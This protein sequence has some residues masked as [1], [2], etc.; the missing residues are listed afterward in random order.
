MAQAATTVFIGCSSTDYA[1]HAA[2]H[3]N[4]IINRRYALV[5][6]NPRLS[7]LSRAEHSAQPHPSVFRTRSPTHRSIS[8]SHRIF[9]ALTTHTRLC[10][11]WTRLRQSGALLG[12]CRRSSS[13]CATITETCTTCHIFR[14]QP[15]CLHSGRCL[16]AASCG[17]RARL[18]SVAMSKHRPP[19]GMHLGSEEDSRTT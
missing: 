3:V 2:K 18:V 16:P 4:N 14:R 17:L 13:C 9:K 1:T 10:A 7:N 12:W 11:R 15:Y 19:L 5:S 8:A 6:Q